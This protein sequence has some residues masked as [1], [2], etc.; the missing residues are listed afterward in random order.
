MALSGPVGSGKT[1]LAMGLSQ[2]GFEM[3][4]TRNILVKN[5]KTAT[6][7]SLQKAGDALDRKTN[8]GWVLDALHELIRSESVKSMFVVDS[9]RIKEQVDAVRQ[10]YGNVIHV[11]LTAPAG[12]L[13]DRYAKRGKSKHESES[14]SKVRANRTEANIESLTATAD[15]V[16]D[17]ARSTESDVLSR[18]IG[19]LWAR[20]GDSGSYVD[21]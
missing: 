13:S 4:K 15:I 19:Q 16:I 8:G 18:V 12:T 10:A 11:H 7:E 9:I 2:L 21:G 3:L 6:R 14:Y 5:A 17:T 20:I 1:T